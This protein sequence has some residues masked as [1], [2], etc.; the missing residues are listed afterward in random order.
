MSDV[1]DRT[2]RSTCVLLGDGAG[3]AVISATDQ[4]GAGIGP[5]VRG[6]DPMPCRLTR[7]G[8]TG[9]GNGRSHGAPVTQSLMNF[10]CIA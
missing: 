5:V 2:D 4:D 9:P 6:S 10:S 8:G 3:V 1:T 7:S